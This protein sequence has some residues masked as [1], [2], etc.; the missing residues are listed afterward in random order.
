MRMV[1]VEPSDRVTSCVNVYGRRGLGM[2]VAWRTWRPSRLGI[3]FVRELAP[4]DE[5]QVEERVARHGDIMAG[6]FP[7]VM[8]NLSYISATV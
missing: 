5:S 1:Y 4:F 8:R 3:E 6:T 2:N 7:I